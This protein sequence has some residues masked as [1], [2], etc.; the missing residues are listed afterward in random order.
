MNALDLFDI[1][2]DITGEWEIENS[3]VRKTGN[4]LNEQVEHLPCKGLQNNNSDELARISQGSGHKWHDNMRL[5]LSHI[6]LE[7]CAI[8]RGGS[9]HLFRNIVLDRTSDEVALDLKNEC[10]QEYKLSITTEIFRACI[11]SQSGVCVA[12]CRLNDA[13][14]SSLKYFSTSD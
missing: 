12:S 6:K 4:P 9:N 1:H 5:P 14:S 10:C 2:C 3:T 13:L 8:V 7:D 11:K